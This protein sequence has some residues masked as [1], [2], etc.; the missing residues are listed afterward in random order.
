MCLGIDTFDRQPL[1]SRIAGAVAR[2]KESVMK[3]CTSIAVDRLVVGRTLTCPIHGMDGVLLVAEG[4]LVTSEL[5]NKLIRRGLCRVVIEE[6]ELAGL[7]AAGLP[8]SQDGAKDELA[9]LLAAHP[10]LQNLSGL[11]ANPH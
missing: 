8:P 2:A 10:S 9:S 5:K 1:S 4:A 11:W 3:T 6:S 7:T